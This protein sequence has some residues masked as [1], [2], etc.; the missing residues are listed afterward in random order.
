MI[1]VGENLL[2]QEQNVSSGQNCEI[3]NVVEV[4]NAT[5]GEHEYGN[6]YSFTGNQTEQ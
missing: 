5:V 2:L 4:P 6:Y 3:N 1:S